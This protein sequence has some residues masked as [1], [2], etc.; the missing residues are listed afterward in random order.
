MKHCKGINI[1]FLKFCINDSFW[2]SCSDMNLCTTIV[3]CWFMKMLFAVCLYFFLISELWK[4]VQPYT[5]PACW[6]SV[7]LFYS[8]NKYWTPVSECVFCCSVINLLTHRYIHCMYHV[9]D[10]QDYL[11]LKYVFVPILVLLFF[12]RLFFYAFWNADFWIK[13]AFLKVFIS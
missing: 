3:I 2:K 6:R 5:T 7:L 11:V 8:I 1:I 9:N 10:L 13:N 12:K 4:H